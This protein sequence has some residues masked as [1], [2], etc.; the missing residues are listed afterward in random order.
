MKLTQTLKKDYRQ[1]LL[2]GAAFLTM[3]LVSYF[4]VGNVVKRQVDLYSRSEIR[5]YQS[6]LSSLILAHEAAL[7]QSASRI[8][9]ALNRNAGSREL[10]EIMKIQ[11]DVLHRQ[12][13][14]RDV[15][16]SVYGYL[17]GNFLDGFGLIPAKYY[18]PK[19]AAWLR[20]AIMNDGI[21]HTEPYADNRTGQAVGAVSIVI[22]DQNGESRGVLAIDYLLSPIIGQVS[23]FRL[24]D[25]GFAS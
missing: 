24:A 23:S 21:Y 6:T 18:N 8:G 11:T 19:T 2:V 14:I 7:Y 17:D 22:Y 3:A 13:D 12:K 16:M 5:F 10:L 15:F 1:L 9:Q 20:G 4:Y 25:S